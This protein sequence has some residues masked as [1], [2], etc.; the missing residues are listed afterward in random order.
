MDDLHTPTVPS[1]PSSNGVRN[2]L[3][4]EELTLQE[5][6]AEKDR[7]EGEITALCAV[8]ESVRSFCFTR[9]YRSSN[10]FKSTK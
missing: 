9:Q 6:I 1:W 7:V 8:L 4:K 10:S 2:G 5:L 3:P